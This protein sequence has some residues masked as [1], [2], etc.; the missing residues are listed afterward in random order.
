MAS[1]RCATRRF[2]PVEAIV[3]DKDGTLC[4]AAEY[5]RTLALR[6]A[7]R[8]DAKVPGVGD[9]LLFAFGL[10][11]DRLAPAGLMNVGS[12]RENEVA[13]AAFLAEK[14]IAWREALRLAEESFAEAEAQFPRLQ[15]APIF[16]DVRATFERLAAAGLK[17]AVLSTDTTANVET[18][19]THHGLTAYVQA[20]WGAEGLVA[21]PDPVVL[22][23]L[24]AMLGTAPRSTLV[25]GDS[26]ID[27][28]LAQ[29]AGAAGVVAV[30]RGLTPA[31]DL[32][33]A[34]CVIAAIEQL[35]VD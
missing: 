16:P 32:A 34:D 25:V 9:A 22:E 11:G 8:L 29:R 27:I 26:P 31:A 2:S 10:E 35:T 30:A 7:R 18:F 28:E 19:V 21:K 12:R 24:S 15:H 3:F 20:A 17:L 23:R 14:G 1:I 13:A 6:R 4:D 5:L 33:A